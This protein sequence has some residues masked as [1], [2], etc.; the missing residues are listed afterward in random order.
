M[1]L[2]QIMQQAEEMKQ[3]MDDIQKEMK[4]LR[5][6][7]ESGGGMVKVEMNGNNEVLN[8]LI[9]DEALQEDKDVLESL[10]TSAV[11]VTAAKVKNE[12]AEKQKKLLGLPVGINFPL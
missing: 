12:V 5:I 2:K 8:I 3:K 10:I 7:G 11:N 6:E 1:D 9:T 4:S